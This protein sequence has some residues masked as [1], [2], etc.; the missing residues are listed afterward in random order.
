MISQGIKLRYTTQR[1]LA[2]LL[3][4]L[5]NQQRTGSPD[6]SSRTCATGSGPGPL[7]VYGDVGK[8]SS[9]DI[10]HLAQPVRCRNRMVNAEGEGLGKHTVRKAIIV[11]G[12]SRANLPGGA[13]KIVV[14]ADTATAAPIIGTER[15][16]V[17]RTPPSFTCAHITIVDLQMCS[18][19][20]DGID[21]T[22]GKSH[23]G[24]AS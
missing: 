8:G 18:A 19:N 13:F 4:R 16:I 22:R 10:W 23:D 11:S 21:G 14:L 15:Q 2:L 6:G 17:T 1:R 3:Q 20:S 7:V 5:V 12:R 24:D 9:S